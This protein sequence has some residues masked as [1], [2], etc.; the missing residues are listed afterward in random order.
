MTDLHDKLTKV[1]DEN[2]GLAKRFAN[3]E[4]FTPIVEEVAGWVMRRPTDYF[5]K[6]LARVADVRA[7]NST[8]TAIYRR[9]KRKWDVAFLTPYPPHKDDLP[10]DPIFADTLR[11][12]WQ[13]LWVA[14]LEQ[15]VE[16]GDTKLLDALVGQRR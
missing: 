3:R 11:E 12:G 7:D 4:V 16:T 10:S 8:P 1:L 2:P 14:L 13:A 15:A 5:D 6:A 9:E